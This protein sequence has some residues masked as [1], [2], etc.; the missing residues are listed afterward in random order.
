MLG[1]FEVHSPPLVFCLTS[2]NEEDLLKVL[3]QEGKV[4]DDDPEGS[5]LHMHT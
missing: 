5:K 4:A 2:L 3:A 1:R